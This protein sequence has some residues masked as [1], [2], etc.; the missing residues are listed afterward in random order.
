MSSI[1]FPQVV[2]YAIITAQIF[3]NFDQLFHLG[4]GLIN[5]QFAI[6]GCY[7]KK[8]TDACRCMPDHVHSSTNKCQTLYTHTLL[9]TAANCMI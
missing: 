9:A 5:A 7:S 8:C 6:D 4:A 3:H 2:I 1:W